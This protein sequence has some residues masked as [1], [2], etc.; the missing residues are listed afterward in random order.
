[1]A[2]AL[3]QTGFVYTI[4]F[5]GSLANT[6][7]PLTASGA[8]GMAASASVVAAG[9][10]NVRVASGAALELDATGSASPTGFTISGHKLTLVGNGRRRARCTRQHRR[11]QR[12]DRTR[13]SSRPTPPWGPTPQPR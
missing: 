9:G 5:G 12:L 2:P 6:Q 4:T 11:Q 10:I 13:S 3:P 1:M 8:D 7:T